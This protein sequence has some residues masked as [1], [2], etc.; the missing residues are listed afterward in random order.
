MLLNTNV[1]EKRWQRLG[2]ERTNDSNALSAGAVGYI[3]VGG[4]DL[5]HPQR[6]I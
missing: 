6:M 2:R 5:L 3:S 1:I 4:Y